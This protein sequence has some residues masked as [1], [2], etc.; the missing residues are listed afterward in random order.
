[1]QRIE[2]IKIKYPV[3]TKVTLINGNKSMIVL[4]YKYIPPVKEIS[5]YTM[6]EE[7]RWREEKESHVTGAIKETY[8][9]FVAPERRRK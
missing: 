6:D 8:I 5:Y 3:G 1:M 9:G 2:K 4:G 7:G